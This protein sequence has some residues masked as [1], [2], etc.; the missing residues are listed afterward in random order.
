MPHILELSASLQTALLRPAPARCSTE[1][2]VDPDGF[3][4][5]LSGY[6]DIER[7][8]VVR[9]SKQIQSNGSQ[10]RYEVGEVSVPLIN[11]DNYFNRNIFGSPF[12][13][14]SAFVITD[15]VETDAF[16]KIRK[17]AAASFDHASISNLFLDDGV[18][19][20]MFTIASIDETD[21]GFDQINFTSSGSIAYTTGS[22]LETTYMPGLPVVLKTVID[23]EAE[24]ITQFTGILKGH[25]VLSDDGAR[26]SIV[27]QEN[28]KALLDAPCT[29]NATHII[30]DYRGNVETTR[31]IER[32]GESNGIFTLDYVTVGTK[33]PIGE[34]RIEF[35]SESHFDIYDP[36]GNVYE[37]RNDTTNYYPTVDNFQL[38]ISSN[39]FIAGDFEDGDVI[40]FQTVLNL[41]SPTNNHNT[42]PAM[43]KALVTES[44]GAAIPVSEIDESSYESLIADYD[45]LHGYI[46]F[47]E[48]LSVM[49]AIEILQSHID[50]TVFFTPDGKSKVFAY[51]PVQ[52]PPTVRSLSPDG[53]VMRLSFDDLGRIEAFKGEYDFSYS[54]KAFKREISA[55][56]RTE[57]GERAMPIKLPA[58]HRGDAQARNIVE[59]LWQRWRK[60]VQVFSVQEQWNYGLALDINDLLYLS[61]DWPSIPQRS[62]EVYEVEKDLIQQTVRLKVYEP[63][64]SFKEDTYLF[65]NEGNLDSGLLVW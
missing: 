14:E 59:R 2:I 32:A 48:S 30:V 49:K 10:G 12:Y 6:L 16:V 33:C 25:P 60:G 50:A 43:L 40:R 53:G 17:G 1:L 37:S 44:I 34:W 35:K 8:L 56:S 27:L 54:D 24:K 46:T 63:G 51:R 61:G 4:I 57:V 64:Y 36:L 20:T 38:K 3:N 42:I 21:P 62:V 58:F 22:M 26:A 18:N 13:Y 11:R 31:I 19:R 45:V 23:G 5:D 9:R 39:A 65:L 41:G 47:T 52:L 15:K 29:A 55:P 28:S 7:S